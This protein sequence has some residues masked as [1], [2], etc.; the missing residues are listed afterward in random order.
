MAK[1]LMKD[2]TEKK[3]S[4][5]YGDL[6]KMEKNKPELAKLYFEIQRKE[7]LNEL[8]L[9]KVIHI[10]YVSTYESDLKFEEFCEQVVNN[11]KIMMKAYSDM[12]YPK[13]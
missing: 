10:A 11:R 12:I 9:A 6:S 8:D 3:I 2:G 13:N 5:G 7:E 1:I 4:L